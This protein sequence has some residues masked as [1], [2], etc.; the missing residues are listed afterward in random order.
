MHLL[1]K[2]QNPPIDIKP[3]KLA[4]LTLYYTHNYVNIYAS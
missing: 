1:E 2:H 3:S 4:G